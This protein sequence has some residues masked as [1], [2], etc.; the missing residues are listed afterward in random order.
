MKD[1]NFLTLFVFFLSYICFYSFSYSII[2]FHVFQ[3]GITFNDQI[4]GQIIR[5]VVELIVLCTLVSLTAR[6]S[7]RVSLVLSLSY[8]LLSIKIFTPIQFYFAAA[9]NG[10]AVFFFYIFYNTAHF[11]NTDKENIGR[12]SALMYS[13]PAIISIVAPF[14][15]GYLRMVSPIFVWII[16]V[17]IFMIS[18]LLINKQKDFRITYSVRSALQEIR[19]TRFYIIIEGIWESLIFGFIPIY[20]LFFIKTP[21]QYGLYLSYLSLIGAIANILFGRLTDKIQKRSL[22]L[23]PITIFMAI[24]T[25]LF[26]KATNDIALWLIVTGMIQFLLPLFWNVTTTLVVDTHVNLRLAIP[27]REMCLAFGKTIGMII[28]F[29]SFTIEKTPYYLFVI[30]GG[31]MLFFPISLYWRTVVKRTHKYL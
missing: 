9:L 5:F 23:Y 26:M 30:L 27:G 29:L 11:E 16:S 15:A 3:Q 2:P 21:V 24:V 13:L 31:V 10:M 25:L 6:F 1:R 17:G 12:N 7:W 19:A 18:F 14:A 8:V 20:S 28:I 22:F 4:F